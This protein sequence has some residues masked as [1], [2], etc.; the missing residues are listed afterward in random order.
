MHGW[1]Q[2]LNRDDAG[3]L[4]DYETLADFNPSL[5]CPNPI[6]IQ[7]QTL[8]GVNWDQLGQV[9][10]CSL[11]HGGICINADQAPM[12]RLALANA[13]FAWASRSLETA[14]GVHRAPLYEPSSAAA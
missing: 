3:G 12:G 13:A 9:Y 14:G 11:P 5:I 2:W 6:A 8:N 7:C 10:S 1:T 4:G